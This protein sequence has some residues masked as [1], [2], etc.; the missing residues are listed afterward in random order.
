LD[1]LELLEK[2][3]TLR[4]KKLVFLDLKSKPP[5]KKK[6]IRYYLLSKIDKKMLHY[7]IPQ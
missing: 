6:A 1:R 4:Q 3:G 7:L 5:N 2:N